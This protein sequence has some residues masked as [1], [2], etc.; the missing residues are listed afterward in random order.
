M[1]DNIKKVLGIEGLKMD[2]SIQSKIDKNAGI[3]T[4]VIK[5]TTLRD[6]QVSGIT[7]KV[8]EKYSRGR[9]KNLLVNEYVMGIKQLKQHISV[10]KNEEKFVDFEVPFQFVKSEMDQWQDQNF[11]M[12]GLISMAKKA[13]GVKS[14]FY[15][16]AEAQE[17]GTKLSPHVVKTF[18]ME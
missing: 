16:L 7:I 18:I 8:M 12:R 11:L 13:K 9:G 15:V 14:E 4:G 6:T 3:I 1:I 17:V 10:K 5:L 2:V